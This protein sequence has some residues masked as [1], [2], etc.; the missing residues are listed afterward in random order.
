MSDMQ[1]EALIERLSRDLAP[2]RRLAPP[3]WRASTWIAVVLVTAL[4]LSHFSDL[5]AMRARMLGAADMWLSM[6]GAIVTMICAAGAAFQTSVPGRSTRWGLLPVPGLVLWIAAGGLG[7]LRGWAVPGAN[8]ATMGE[9]RS[10]IGFIIAMSV[11]LCILLVLMLRRACPLRPNLTAAM[12]GLAAAS[13]SA[14]LL[15]FFHPLDASATDLVGHGLAVGIV[16][17]LN[18]ALGGRL[19]AASPRRTAS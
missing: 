3:W 17:S 8:A 6:L 2:T 5:I 19:L 4:V 11:P 10:C 12:A 13:A 15:M 7:C 18:R 14:I 9:E 16:I 1:H